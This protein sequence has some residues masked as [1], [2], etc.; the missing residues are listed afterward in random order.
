MLLGAL[1]RLRCVSRECTSPLQVDVFASFSAVSKIAQADSPQPQVVFIRSSLLTSVATHTSRLEAA[2]GFCTY[3]SPLDASTWL[4]L[5]SIESPPT[6]YAQSTEAC[7][8]FPTV[9]ITR[10]QPHLHRE[11]Y[12]STRPTMRSYRNIHKESER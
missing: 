1:F 12:I 10:A 4:L 5:V 3:H 2:V 8:T 11:L 9:F 7:I 6:A